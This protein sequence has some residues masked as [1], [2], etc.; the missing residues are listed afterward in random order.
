MEWY[1]GLA[2]EQDVK[3]TDSHIGA[4]WY[5]TADDVPFPE[6]RELPESYNGLFPPNSMRK[7][8][9]LAK[10]ALRKYKASFES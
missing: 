8:F 10:A 6:G 9:A 1:V 4:G 7:E 5:L 2:K 3:L